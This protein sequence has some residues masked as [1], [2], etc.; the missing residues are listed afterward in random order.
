MAMYSREGEWREKEKEDGVERRLVEPGEVGSIE[1]GR[2]GKG[3]YG[4]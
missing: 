1:E 2:E 3:T 4:E